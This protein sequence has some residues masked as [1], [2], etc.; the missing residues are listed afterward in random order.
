MMIRNINRDDIPY[1]RKHYENKEQ[2]FWNL[3]LNDYKE[4]CFIARDNDNNYI[5]CLIST[6][7]WILKIQYDSGFVGVAM[8]AS[9]LNKSAEKFITIQLNNFPLKN[10][11]SS[12]GFLQENQDIYRF[13]S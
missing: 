7:K 12:M 1:L 5:G 9:C 13:A 4:H 10:L 2:Q 6:D 11:V 8:L 3:L